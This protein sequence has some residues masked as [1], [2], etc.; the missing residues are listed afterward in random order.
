M[1][2][3]WSP[4]REQTNEHCYHSRELGWGQESPQ[5]LQ[6]PLGLLP[7]SSTTVSSTGQRFPDSTHATGTETHTTLILETGILARTPAHH[8]VKMH[9][10][11][12]RSPLN[13]SG[14][15]KEGIALEVVTD[16]GSLPVLQRI[17]RFLRGF[18]PILLIKIILP[19]PIYCSIKKSLSG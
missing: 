5:P 19:S 2:W 7:L 10:V 15:D 17:Y 13:Q 12:E 9:V 14:S 18:P 3:L 6:R 11:L 16:S 4:K 1:W 8:R